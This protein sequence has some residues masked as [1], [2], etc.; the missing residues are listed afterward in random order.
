MREVLQMVLIS[1]F[2]LSVCGQSPQP[3]L[4]L[5]TGMHMAA[6]RTITTTKDGRL[7]LTAGE[8]KTARL[9][10]AATGRLLHT[11]RI[12]IGVGVKSA[13][14]STLISSPEEGK[15][16][17][18][19]ISPNG[20]YI[21]LGG[22]TGFE[23]DHRG[24]IYILD[25]QTGNQITRIKDFLSDIDDIEFSANGRWLGACDHYSTRI[26]ETQSWSE[27]QK[28]DAQGRAYQNIAF[29]SDNRLAVTSSVGSL[30]VYGL[31]TLS[32]SASLFRLKYSISQLLGTFPVTVSFS[33]DASVIAIGFAGAFKAEVRESQS[34]KLLFLPSCQGISEDGKAQLWTICFSNDGKLYAGGTPAIF[35]KSKQRVSN[36]VRCWNNGG[37]GSYIDLPISQGPIMCIRALSTGGIVI[38]SSTPE[39]N[40]LSAAHSLKWAL[41][42]SKLDFSLNNDA[43]FRLNNDASSF[44]Y[45]APGKVT[46]GFDAKSRTLSRTALNYPSSVSKN[47]GSV[48]TNFASEKGG[49]FNGFPISQYLMEGETAFFADVAS[50]G[51]LVLATGMRLIHIS[52][53]GKALRG[54]YFQH[55]PTAIKISGNVKVVAVA[56][57]DG[58]IRWYRMTDMNGFMNHFLSLFIDNKGRSVL[59]TPSGYYDAAPGAEDLLGWHVNNGPD[60]TPNFFPVSR[61]RETYYRPDVIDAILETYDETGAVTLANSRSTKKVQ[62]VASP[63]EVRN[64]RP[65]VVSIISPATGS[66]VRSETVR[67]D[68]SLST[69]DD[70]PVKS[71]KVLVNGRPVALER[72]IQKGSSNK[73]FVNVTIPLRKPKLYVLAIGISAYQNADYK[74]NFADKD[75]DAFVNTMVKQKGRLYND[76]VVR[77]LTNNAAT[78]DAIADGLEWIQR[79]TSQGDIAMIFYAG[80][81]IN[82][83]NGTFFM[84]PVGGDME[85]IRATCLNFEELKQT[86]SNIAGK[87]AV[88]IDACHSGNA[89]G[90]TRRGAPDINAIINDLSSTQNGAATFSS[91]TGKEFSLEDASWTHGAFTLALIEGLSGKADLTGKGKVTVNTLAAYIA[92]RVKDLTKG[93]QHPTLVLP[94][95][96]PDFAIAIF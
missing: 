23:W 16:Y 14:G 36:I 88:F 75:A 19:S 60:V 25:A 66:T 85:R 59:F 17:A 18:A 92:E 67:I 38:L 7:I 5:E 77:K 27:L 21:A 90:S 86:V 20:T 8:D 94:P 45:S 52:K 72:G 58:I 1:C 84:L 51:S 44:S 95:N 48:L 22:N 63:T 35:E 42:A 83:N 71:I 47:G 73:S 32:Q 65:P 11:Y 39:I 81:G 41:T 37:R 53:E 89:M 12:P 13:D 43:N 49:T 2:T 46:V 70:A 62:T 93:K 96:V 79:E 57:T 82:D 34:G 31:E 54:E 28:F 68:Y 4:Q 80:H 24:S 26:Y 29:S 15:I 10:E 76:V 64:K 56:H 87:V 30:S 6:G 61:Y 55:T 69:P 33:P 91:S 50:D 40:V 74:L 3:M 9:W 78:R